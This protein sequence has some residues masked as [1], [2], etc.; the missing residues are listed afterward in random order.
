MISKEQYHDMKEYWDYQRKVEYNREQCRQ[1][2][3]NDVIHIGDDEI[4]PEELF[5]I[6]WPRIDSADYDDPPLNW[7][8]KNIDYRLEGEVYWVDK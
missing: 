5:E 6:M 3:E 4:G 7:I 1:S 8:P 2:C